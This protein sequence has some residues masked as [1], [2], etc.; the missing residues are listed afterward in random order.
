VEALDKVLGALDK[1]NLTLNVSKCRIA[2]SSVSFIGHIVSDKGIGPNMD[3]VKAIEAMGLPQSVSE[4]RTVL[5]KLSYYRSFISDFSRTSFPLRKKM[6]MHGSWRKVDGAVVY[7]KEE[8]EAFFKLRG[9]LL[10]EPIMASPDY[11][12]P[13]EVHCDAS[14]RGLGA[15]LTQKTNGKEHVIS[16]ASRSLIPIEKSYSIWELESLAA[17]WSMRLWKLFLRGRPFTLVT[18]S[19]ATKAILDQSY[20]K[21]GG[22][23]MRWSLAASESTIR[24][25]IESVHAISTRT[26]YPT[27][28][29]LQQN[30]TTKAPRR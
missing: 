28:L 26:H 27:S 18:D 10:H 7:T 5:G 30:L 13:F 19:E 2:C 1:F 24:L 25:S 9:A 21:G 8:T 11:D 22:R 14:L 15:T 17:I 12:K 3:K 16:Y 4:M 23:L 29:W 20:S 6:E